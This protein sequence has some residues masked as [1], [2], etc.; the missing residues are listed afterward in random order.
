[1]GENEQG[2]MLRTV[3][4]MGIIAMVALII[5]LGVV[6]LKANMRKNI[7]NGIPPMLVIN[8]LEPE[9]MKTRMS[10]F[11]GK[12]WNAIKYTDVVE[13]GVIT[14][15]R[16]MNVVLDTRNVSD[17]KWALVESPEYEVPTGAKRVKLSVTVKGGG[18]RY[19]YSRVHFYDKDGHYIKESTAG[20]AGSFYI[21]AITNKTLDD[22]KT[23]TK[24]GKVPAN[25]VK[26]DVSMES[27]EKMLVEYKDV[28][29]TVYEW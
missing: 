23:I 7:D 21:D 3:V 26:M 1:M 5:T 12:D 17:N 4:V 18:P 20:T 13:P 27:R 8:A 11:D 28:T 25:A 9:Q 19:A 10:S 22:F 29:A 24:V 6:G 14:I 2:G 15:K 16:N